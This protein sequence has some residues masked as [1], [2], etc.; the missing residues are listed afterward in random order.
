MDDAA[1]DDTSERL[2]WEALCAY[3]MMAPTEHLLN[4]VRAAGAAEEE[5]DGLEQQVFEGLGER[6][7]A[8]LLRCVHDPVCVQL[9][10]KAEYTQR[11]L[12]RAVQLAEAAG[13]E[14]RLCTPTVHVGRCTAEDCGVVVTQWLPLRYCLPLF[15]CCCTSWRQLS[16]NPNE[17]ARPGV[18]RAV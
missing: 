6:A 15:N 4:T 16:A 18:Q 14:V 7:Q 5:T 10:P 9:P 2:A 1:L 3:R 17:N 13:C 11:V 12:K 8:V